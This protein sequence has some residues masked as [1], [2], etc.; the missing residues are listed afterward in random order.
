M[1]ELGITVVHGIFP[2][3]VTDKRLGSPSVPHAPHEM[4]F[5]FGNHKSQVPAPVGPVH[6]LQVNGYYTLVLEKEGLDIIQVFVNM[7]LNP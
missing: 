2:Q 3:E 5:Q 4:V 6:F 7:K 1:E